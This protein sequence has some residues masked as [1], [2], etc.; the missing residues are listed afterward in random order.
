MDWQGCSKEQSGG[1]QIF[2]V[3]RVDSLSTKCAMF[4]IFSQ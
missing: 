1:S 3:L 2:I 4:T